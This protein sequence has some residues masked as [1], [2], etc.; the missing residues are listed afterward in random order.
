[1]FGP[2][3]RSGLLGSSQPF[4]NYEIYIYLITGIYFNLCVHDELGFLQS[5]TILVAIL[6]VLVIDR[7]LNTGVRFRQS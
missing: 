5:L 4:Y 2:R 7:T 1:M 3:R 6:K